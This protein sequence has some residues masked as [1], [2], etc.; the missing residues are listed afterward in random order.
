MRVEH[1][2]FDRRL[3]LG[4]TAASASNRTEATTAVPKASVS[5]PHLQWRKRA[6][7]GTP[8]RPGEATASRRLRLLE[9][10][11]RLSALSRSAPICRCGR[12]D[13][14]IARSVGVTGLQFRNWLREQRGAGHPL[15]AGHEY[16]T[17]YRF[18]RAEADQLTAEFLSETPSGESIR[19]VAM[20]SAATSADP[21]PGLTL[22]KDLGHRV[23]EPMGKETFT[24]ADLL[25]PG[26]RAVVVGINPSPISV[27]AGHY[28]QGRLGQRFFKRLDGA[29]VVDLSGAGW[30][31]DCA[32][33]TGI[34][35]TDVVKRPTAR[36]D[37]LRPSELQHGRELLGVKL[38]ELC[39]R[40]V[41]FTF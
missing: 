34:G 32:F 38:L 25:R 9:H 1:C 3:A 29:A 33:R 14:E 2:S 41:L 15:L 7:G 24:L 6:S 13:S 5:V 18:T 21:F 19:P 40:K 10:R 30:A 12:R 37:G 36:A 28:Y 31:D 17:R 16:R 22:S 11:A 23:T 27:A 8:E 26:L 35:F 20:P 39:V 4:E